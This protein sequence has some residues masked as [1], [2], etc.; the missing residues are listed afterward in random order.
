MIITVSREFGS[1]GREIGMR[2]ARELGLQ[3]FDKEIVAEI[4]DRT[5]LDEHYV[6]TVLDKGGY[7]SFSFSFGRSLP[8]IS[9]APDV[10][11]DV[12]VAQ[13]Q[14]IRALGAKGNCLVVGRCAEELL[15][16][17][18][19]FRIFVYADDESKIKRCRAR[20]SEN[21]N[22]SDKQ[23]IKKFREIDKGR[24]QLHDLVSPNEWGVRSEY[25]LMINTSRVDIDKIIAPLAEYIRSFNTNR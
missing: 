8:M 25:E 14:V 4:A 2:L 16:Q 18:K 15:K 17:Y 5:E 22:Y 10:V 21:E 1:G 6:E 9:A 13:Q 3:Y 7:K 20:A 19:P 24:K 23:L 11:T 12:L